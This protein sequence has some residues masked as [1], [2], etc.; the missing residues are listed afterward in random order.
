MSN[1]FPN[2]SKRL[3]LVIMSLL[4]LR[5]CPSPTRDFTKY[6]G[7]RFWATHKERIEPSDRWCRL[8]NGRPG[9]RASLATRASTRAWCHLGG[10]QSYD[11]HFL[12]IFFGRTARTVLSRDPQKR[13]APR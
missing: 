1:L 3:G 2:R 7:E 4:E 5:L 8:S 12:S 10:D 13:R 11:P 6:D 9:R